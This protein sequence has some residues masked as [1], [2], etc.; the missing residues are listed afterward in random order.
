MASGDAYE[1]LF[2]EI[3]G[4][5]ASALGEAGRRQPAKDQSQK[6]VERE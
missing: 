5:Q 3:R 4:E 6:I 1:A 2:A